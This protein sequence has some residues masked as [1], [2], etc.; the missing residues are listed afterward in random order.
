METNNSMVEKKYVRKKMKNKY[1]FYP[2]NINKSNRNMCFYFFSLS[3][4]PNSRP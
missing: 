2:K 4:H 1:F 3:F